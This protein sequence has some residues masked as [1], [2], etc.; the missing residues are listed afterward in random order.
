MAFSEE[1]AVWCA[2]RI[3]CPGMVEQL[4]IFVACVQRGACLCYLN[5][6]PLRDVPVAVRHG[7]FLVVYKSESSRSDAAELLPHL[8]PRLNARLGMVRCLPGS[9]R[10]GLNICPNN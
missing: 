4:G 10:L 2:E 5:G 3:S 9:R 8:W 6:A 7:D 1:G